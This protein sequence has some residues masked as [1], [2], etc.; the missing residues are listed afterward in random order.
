MLRINESR[1]AVTESIIQE[2]PSTRIIGIMHA[3]TDT[4]TFVK[5]LYANRHSMEMLFGKPHSQDPLVIQRLE[6][7]GISMH[8]LKNYDHIEGT[9]VLRDTIA[10]IKN[11][12]DTP[13][14]IVDTGG[15][16]A[17]PLRAMTEE[18]PEL[19]PN[20]ILEVTTFGHNR[21]QECIQ[22]I[23]TPVVSI[24][25]SPLKDV[26]AVFVGESAWL[27]LDKVFRE[28]GLSISGHS[29]GMVGY[30]MIGRR[31]VDAALHGGAH[32]SVYDANPIKQLDARSYRHQPVASL[33]ELLAEN[34]IV[35]ASTGGQ[36]ISFE[37]MLNY[38]KNGI[39]L[40]SA[41]SRTQEIDMINL[42]KYATSMRHIHD[43]LAEYSLQN[44]K[45]IFIL[46]GGSS[47]NFLVSSCPDEAMDIVFAEMIAG[48]RMTL[49][50]KL[51]LGIM[52]EVH[53]S[54]RKDIATAWLSRMA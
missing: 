12:S 15:Y 24:A 9:S 23:S 41:G 1:L 46:R 3:L 27:G 17:E 10:R 48:I 4:E 34:D 19:L 14:S 25:R 51:P 37:M 28:V 30:G 36:S 13:L 22:D 18:E 32:T 21:Y 6:S 43:D 45:T 52:H 20:G 47:I 2:C 53:D 40:G 16:F 54:I 44:G 8:A 35:L 31:V 5:H 11:I 50:E 33:E 39:V 29:L 26:E 49:N 42:K 7:S 38:A